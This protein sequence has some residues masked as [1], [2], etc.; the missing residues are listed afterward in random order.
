MQNENQVGQTISKISKSGQD[1]Q[2]L[3]KKQ[4]TVQNGSIGPGSSVHVSST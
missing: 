3:E 4:E 1:T 2:N